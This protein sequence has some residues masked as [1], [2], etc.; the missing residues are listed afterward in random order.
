[1]TAIDPVRIADVLRRVRARR[2]LVHVIT[3]EVAMA[4]TANILLAIGAS[5]AMVIGVEEAAEFAARADALLV[6]IGTLT[7]PRAQAMRL[8]AATAGARGVPWV[9][10]PVGAGA[11]A[12]RSSVASEFMR[13]RPTAIRGN[14][15]EIAT[16]AGATTAPMRGVDATLA[17]EEALA[18]A[19]ALARASG[20]VI[21]MT[22]AVDYVASGAR[23]VR[24]ANGDPMMAR[25]TALG[26]SASALVAAALAV[27]AETLL[28]VVAALAW[29]AVAGEIAA[30]GASGPGTLQPR[31]L[32]ALFTLDEP[33]LVARVR[34]A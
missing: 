20:A 13:A 34:L 22:G 12:H 17:A 5:P 16:L 29:M 9:L 27:E 2:P 28:A 10:D 1:M 6:N 31:L 11:T 32:D 7:A 3:N 19:I 30:A 25:V 33:A 24:L 21:G 26:C 23:I 14:A 8:A 18:P 15:S 4:L